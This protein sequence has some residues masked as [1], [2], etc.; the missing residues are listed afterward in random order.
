[1]GKYFE[2]L[3]GQ[4][5]RKRFEISQKA[6]PNLKNNPNYTQIQGGKCPIAFP[7]GTLISKGLIDI[8]IN[9]G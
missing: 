1:M 4:R 7:L 2:L 6:G 8:E 3:W 5:L 9:I